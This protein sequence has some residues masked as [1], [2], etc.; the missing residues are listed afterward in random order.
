MEST[1]AEFT[2]DIPAHV[3]GRPVADMLNLYESGFYLQQQDNWLRHNSRRP[4]KWRGSK[5]P[6][7]MR[8]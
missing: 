3:A 8:V 6:S 4:L 1:A 5:S 7:G 2:S